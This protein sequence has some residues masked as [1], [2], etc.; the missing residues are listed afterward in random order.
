MD[1]QSFVDALRRSTV[2]GRTSSPEPATSGSLSTPSR[3]EST[4]GEVAIRIINLVSNDTSAL[5]QT[6]NGVIDEVPPDAIKT[7]SSS[8]Y[9]RPTPIFEFWFHAC[10]QVQLFSITPSNLPDWIFRLNMLTCLDTH[11]FYNDDVPVI[12]SAR[13]LSKFFGLEIVGAEPMDN[14]DFV[15]SVVTAL[16]RRVARDMQANLNASLPAKDFLDWS[17]SL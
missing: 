15:D 3:S 9:L 7:S 12:P 4:G 14:Q 8:I 5:F 16:N 10:F 1:R 17:S 6:Y 11:C 2:Y 13:E